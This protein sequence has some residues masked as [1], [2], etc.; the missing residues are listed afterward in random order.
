MEYYNGA[1]EFAEKH[2]A[3]VA[4]EL[5]EKVGFPEAIYEEIK[6]E[7]YLKLL[8]PEELGGLG[9]D[10]YDHSEII[11][12]FSEKS[13]TVGLTYM[14]HNVA[15]NI[16]LNAGKEELKQK[17]VREVVE[18]GKTLALAYSESGSGVSF[19]YP[20]TTA[21]KKGDKWL[22]NGSKSMVTSAEYASYYM[23]IAK[24]GE[25]RADTDNFCVPIESEGLEFKMERWNGIGLRGN[26]SCPMYMD[27]ME[28]DEMYRTGD[29]NSGM[30]QILTLVAPLFIQGLAS[31]YSGLNVAISNEAIMHA[32]DRTFP[33]GSKL[34]EVDT[35]KHHLSTIYNNAFAGV[36]ATREAAL[37]ARR[38]DEDALPKIL[39]ARVI[40]IE[41]VTESGKLGMQ[42][43]GGRAYSQFRNFA[44]YLADALAGQVMAPS[45]D[46]LHQWIGSVLTG[47]MIP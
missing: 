43:G 27:N 4:R 34:S 9:G 14:M 15:L 32:T 1:K 39:S 7:G 21:E 23:V 33:D 10:I 37:A 6:K 8:I 20:E 35:I 28:L 13:A 45:L 2:I 40:A 36:S 17:I 19:Y 41:N 12:A 3:P 44:Y 16:V 22:L 46:I 5:S 26:V 29:N 25:G 42:V 18:E 11:R 38:G 47:Q 30:E 24:T 31:V